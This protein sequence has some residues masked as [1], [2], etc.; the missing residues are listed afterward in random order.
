MGLPNTKRVSDE[1]EVDTRVGSGTTVRALIVP[2]ER[3]LVGPPYFHSVRLDS[4]RCKGC[5][6]CIKGCPTEAIRVR[7]GKALILEDRCID[8]GECIRRCPNQ[9]KFAATSSWEELA[10]Y[11][12]KVALVAPSFYGQFADAD[13]G[14]VAGALIGPGG[15]DEVFNVARAADL[16]SRLMREY[17]EKT[18]R[19]R[20]LISP[21]CPVVLRLIQVRFPSLLD[22]V[23][24]CEAPMEIAAWMVKTRLGR[25]LPNK[26]IGVF[27]IT[28]CPAKV[29]ASRQP[30]GRGRSLVDGTIAVSRACLWVREHLDQARPVPFPDS[31]GL[32]IGWGRSG[33]EMA[34]VG[35]SGLAVDGISAVASVLEEIEKGQFQDIDFIEAQACTGGCVGGPLT[36]ENPFVARL[37]IRTLAVKHRTSPADPAVFS[38]PTDEPSV[39]F[40]QPLLPRP[41]YR[42]DEDPDRASEVRARIDEVERELPGLDCGAC[43]APTCRSLA[44]DAVIGRGSVWDC[45]FKLREKLQELSREVARLSAILPPAM[46]VG[47][48][49]EGPTGPWG[50]PRLEIRE[51]TKG[52]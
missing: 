20:P 47:R 21:A 17:V 40:T 23:I 11:D 13:P 26:R 50:E 52:Q 33:G 9:A 10:D 3:D 37:R 18:P 35:M 16:A 7:A 6:N 41:V 31:T 22:H 42:L 25:E 36:V 1:L 14:R 15:F 28:P 46:G 43:G 32:G 24:P 38:V 27:F 34:A 45:V 39:W 8:C 44:E 2:K 48:G 4:G 29:T 51:E 19:P 12:Y 5:T 30:V 49:V